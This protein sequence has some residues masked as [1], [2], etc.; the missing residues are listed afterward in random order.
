MLANYRKGLRVLKDHVVKFKNY[1]TIATSFSIYLEMWEWESIIWAKKNTIMWVIQNKKEN[2]T[3]ITGNNSSFPAQVCYH[4]L[5]NTW[6]GTKPRI[7][8]WSNSLLT[9]IG[10][11]S[12]TNLGFQLCELVCTTRQTLQNTSLLEILL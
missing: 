6:P 9:S 3:K 4:L 8:G 11:G 12:F 7:F 1:V 5:L 2:S 10:P